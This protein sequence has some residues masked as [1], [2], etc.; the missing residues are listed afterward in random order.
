M[1][2]Q[3]DAEPDADIVVPL[4]VG[5]ETVYLAVRPVGGDADPGG[6][7][8][9]AARRPTLDDVIGGLA[10]FADGLS[11]RLRETGASK[12]SVEF[13]CEVAAESGTFVAVI[14]KASAKST[15]KVGLE[16]TKPTA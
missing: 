11:T 8:E 15:F 13:G 12:V 4:T 7:H 16:W 9:I 5:G 10:A 14:G 6:E 1:T 3:A 2:Q